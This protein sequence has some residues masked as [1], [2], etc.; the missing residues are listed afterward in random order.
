MNN[1]Q[2][3]L[4]Q[5]TQVFGPSYGTEDSSIFLYSLVKMHRPKTI[6][7]IGTGLGV[8]AFQMAMAV[9]ENDYG[10]VYTLDD[11]SHWERNHVLAEKLA[12]V[13]PGT[14]YGEFLDFAADKIGLTPFVTFLSDSVPPYPTVDEPIDL[15]FSDFL[16]GPDNILELLAFYLPL[17]SE[18]CSIFIDSAS[19]LRSSYDL[20]EDLIP[21]LNTGKPPDSLMKRVADDQH[22]AFETLLSQRRYSLIHLTERKNRSQNSMAWIRVEPREGGPYPATKM[23]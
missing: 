9:R 20:L 12:L 19:T 18:C 14:A 5:Y 21:Q 10:H 3:K 11:G 13:P 1:Q 23:R 15:L 7:E 2:L 16:H 17:V 4:L 6:L 8:C 22:A